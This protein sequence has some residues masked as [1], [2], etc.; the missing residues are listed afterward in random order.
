MGDRQ[1][2]HIDQGSPG[3]EIV[4][5]EVRVQVRSVCSVKRVP[6]AF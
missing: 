5:V 4:E 6:R 2:R 3:A 1:A